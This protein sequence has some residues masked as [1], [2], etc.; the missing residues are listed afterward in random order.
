MKR[1]L[2]FVVVVSSLASFAGASQAHTPERYRPRKSKAVVCPPPLVPSPN[3]ECGLGQIDPLPPPPR[4]TCGFTH[5]PVWTHNRTVL[6]VKGAWSG[7]SHAVL[8]LNG[9]ATALDA[10][11]FNVDL[12]VVTPAPF[13]EV[14]LVVGVNECSAL[15]TVLP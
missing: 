2:L 10:S 6:K 13:Y 15:V 4:T 1:L 14:W 7:T 9:D 5:P 12:P 8:T 11:P 3:G